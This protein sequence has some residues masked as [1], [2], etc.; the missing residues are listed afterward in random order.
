MIKDYRKHAPFYKYYLRSKYFFKVNNRTTGLMCS[1]VTIKASVFFYLSET[2][3]PISYEFY[4][5]K[6]VKKT[7]IKECY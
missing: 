7:P 2:L 6:N 4:N 3:Y 5:L 1:K